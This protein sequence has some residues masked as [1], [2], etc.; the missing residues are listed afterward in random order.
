[1]SISGMVAGI[2]FAN[3]LA[4]VAENLAPRLRSP[5]PRKK[6]KLAASRRFLSN[7]SAIVWAIADLPHPT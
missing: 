2:F 6:K 7:L 4:M 5:I 1:M 3:W